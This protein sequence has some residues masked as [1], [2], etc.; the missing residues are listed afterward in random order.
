[1]S[2]IWYVPIWE[3]E[4]SNWSSASSS[5][6]SFINSHTRCRLAVHSRA[7]SALASLSSRTGRLPTYTR[8]VPCQP[9]AYSNGQVKLIT[10]GTCTTSWPVGCL[11]FLVILSTHD[12]ATHKSPRFHQEFKKTKKLKKKLSC[13][14]VYQKRYLHNQETHCPSSFSATFWLRFAGH[15]AAVWVFP[16]APAAA[17]T[18]RGGCGPRDGPRGEPGAGAAGRS[19]EGLQRL[20]RLHRLWELLVAGDEG[21]AVCCLN[22]VSGTL[23]CRIP[24]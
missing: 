10:G 14:F 4:D 9:S 12:S 5:S 17:A 21:S 24:C 8:N 18:L 1:M 19:F 15:A 23:S 20:Q 6:S 7:H 13:I 16:A 3:S 2:P 22:V 11:V